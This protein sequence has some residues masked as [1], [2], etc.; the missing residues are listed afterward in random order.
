[1]NVDGRPYRTIWL[2]DDGASVGVID[3]TLLPHR[4]E[5][6]R[7]RT[8]ED[9]ATGIRNMVVRGAPLI[10]AAAAYG[11]ALAMQDDSGDENLQVAYDTLFRT[12]PT[13]VNL[14]W[15]LDLMRQTLYNS[16]ERTGA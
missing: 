9:A 7:W 5:V 12:R 10:G 14:R 1:M 8:V 6:V 15:A 2:N 4:F 13:A 11:M 16:A 3:Q